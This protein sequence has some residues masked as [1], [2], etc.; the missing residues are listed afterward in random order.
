MGNLL[1]Y[2]SIFLLGLWGGKE[3]SKLLDLSDSDFSAEI[4]KYTSI[5]VLFL[6][7]QWEECKL[8]KEDMESA[9]D[10]LSKLNP[11]SYAAIVDGTHQPK[12]IEEYEISNYP[13]VIFFLNNLPYPYTGDFTAEKIYVWIKSRINQLLHSNEDYNED[14]LLAEFEAQINNIKSNNSIGKLHSFIKKVKTIIITSYLKYYSIL[15]QRIKA[16]SPK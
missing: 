8:M 12:I 14:Q 7:P 3:G 6:N 15:K 4:S 1:L 5:L 10:L 13:S 16:E 11:P 2:L 9:V